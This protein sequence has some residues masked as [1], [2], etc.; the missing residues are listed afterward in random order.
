[1]HTKKKI[2]I[3]FLLLI[4]KIIL[5][6]TI[7]GSKHDLSNTNY[8]GPYS[9]TNTEVCVFCHTPHSSST[10]IDGPLWNRRIT[11]SSVFTLYNG[12]NEVPNSPSLVCLS[13]HDGVSA[14][15]E[16][17]A[18]NGTD[19]H[20]VINSPG[21]GHESNPVTPNCYACHFSG[22]IYPGVE[23]TIG[24]NL[25]DDHP[26]SISYGSAKDKDP[27][28]FQVNPLNGLKLYNG[29]VECSSCHDPHS[30]E[31]PAFLRM[32]NLDSELCKSCHIK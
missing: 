5:N 4:S 20:N 3:I 32:S 13:C 30:V 15:G 26:V 9:G 6:A 29:N 19:M 18:V 1:L 14:N 16:M 27:V 21:S 22:D 31:F 23:W 17:S 7:V 11:D 8:Y 12:A 24:P 2:K 25:T 28:G 10:E